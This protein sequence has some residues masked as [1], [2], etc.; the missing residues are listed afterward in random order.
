MIKLRKWIRFEMVRIIFLRRREEKK[1]FI[2]VA[3][4]TKN[5]ILNLLSVRRETFML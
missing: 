3:E 2:S 1:N 4:R 5:L